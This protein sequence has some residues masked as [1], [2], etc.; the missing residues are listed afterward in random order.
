MVVANAELVFVIEVK[1]H[2][3]DKAQ[4]GGLV[5]IALVGTGLVAKILFQIGA[6]R[7]QIGGEDAGCV[8]RY[9]LVE[10]GPRHIVGAGLGQFVA[11]GIDKEKEFVLDDRAAQADANAAVAEGTGVVGVGFGFGAH[12]TLITGQ[13]INRAGKFVGSALGDG[14]DAGAHKITLANVIGRD[15][16]LQLFDGLQRDRCHAGAV[17]GLS[18]QTERVVEIG[19]VDGD[20]VHAVI[21]ARE[22]ESIAGRV[23]LRCQT[24]KIFDSSCDGGQGLDC[25]FADRGGR[26]GT[27]SAHDGATFSRRHNFAKVNGFLGQDKINLRVLAQGQ[28]DIFD[29]FGLV[30]HKPRRDRI[31][32]ANAHTGDV[33]AP[34]GTGI[35]A[36]GRAAR[37]MNGHD[38][39]ADQGL[40]VVVDDPAIQGRRGDALCP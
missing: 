7:I 40:A 27:R 35:D 28:V 13:A 20:V 2:F 25:L 21:L 14:V 29:L 32:T 4:G 5:I 19:T 39:G 23:V 6:Q 37:L 10:I 9:R 1:I 15:V 22:G 33:I 24:G 30:T 18:C 16:D 31:G 3:G 11:L 34:V 26:A 38:I 8:A 36:K 12:Q 17:A